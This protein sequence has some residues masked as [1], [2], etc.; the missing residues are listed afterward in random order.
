MISNGREHIAL[1]NFDEL[2]D[3]CTD[4]SVQP[5]W[6]LWALST[7]ELECIYKRQKNMTQFLALLRVSFAFSGFKDTWKN[8]KHLSKGLP[9]FF[10]G[11]DDCLCARQV[12][13]KYAR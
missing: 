4:M 6:W 13:I 10:A 2:I 7:E 1:A 12:T 9:L 3:F 5:R 8:G 11:I